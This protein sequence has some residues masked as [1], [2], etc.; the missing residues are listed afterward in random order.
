VRHKRYTLKCIV[1]GNDFI[2]TRNDAKTCS[3]VCRGKLKLQKVRSLIDEKDRMIKT[4]SQLINTQMKV[5]S[6]VIPISD[7]ATMERTDQGK[8]KIQELSCKVGKDLTECKRP[9]GSRL[10]ADHDLNNL[11]TSI[12]QVLE[13]TDD[14]N[15]LSV[16]NAN[17]LCMK[18]IMAF[19]R[20]FKCKF[21]GLGIPNPIR[22]TFRVRPEYSWPYSFHEGKK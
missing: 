15:L 8:E 18:L 10:Y 21:D 6:S 17:E 3:E 14:G 12:A 11:R 20:Q 9:D 2:A 13:N 16:L 1:C 7:P 5:L 19:E 4:Q 22:N